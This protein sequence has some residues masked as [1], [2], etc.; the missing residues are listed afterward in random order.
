MVKGMKNQKWPVV[1]FGLLVLIFGVLSGLFLYSKTLV[2]LPEYSD[3]NPTISRAD[4]PKLDENPFNDSNFKKYDQKKFIKLQSNINNIQGFQNLKIPSLTDYQTK[5]IE[6]L[7]NDKKILNLKLS[8]S[9]KSEI[10]FVL[11]QFV[12]AKKEMTCYTD[13]KQIN[14][15]LVR[16]L[17]KDKV[18]GK[19][20]WWYIK[21]PTK[22][23]I[24]DTAQFES[25]FKEFDEKNSTKFNKINK[26]EARL[27]TPDFEILSTV[28]DSGK[29]K[30]N[31]ADS[32]NISTFY[33]L[34]VSFVGNQNDLLDFD[35]VMNA[36]RV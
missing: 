16:V 27:C 19:T 9:N 13:F 6:S 5:L 3:Y 26:E 15:T 20:A 4:N 24:I 12:E 22:F 25:D 8:N 28:Y 1:L 18:G 17:K 23:S 29:T 31:S 11:E 7:K 32:N 30:N 34:S 10:N 21:I 36:V 35:D 14:E 33:N 2:G